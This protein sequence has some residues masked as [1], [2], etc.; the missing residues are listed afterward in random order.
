MTSEKRQ[1]QET[2]PLLAQRNLAPSRDYDTTAAQRHDIVALPLTLSRF[3]GLY[4]HTGVLQQPQHRP[5]LDGRVV[6]SQ[7]TLE[8]GISM[9]E[10]CQSYFAVVQ[11]RMPVPGS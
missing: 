8:L 1:Q 10:S 11:Q 9:D 7:V 4:L 3:V 2:A 6:R 5:S